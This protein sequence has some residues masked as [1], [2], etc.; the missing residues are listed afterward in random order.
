MF[1]IIGLRETLYLYIVILTLSH[2]IIDI[3]I[4]KTS[5]STYLQI[6]MNQDILD[7]LPNRSMEKEMKELTPTRYR[8][9]IT[10]VVYGAILLSIFSILTFS[11]VVTAI[12]QPLPLPTVNAVQTTNNPVISV[13]AGAQ[14]GSQNSINTTQKSAINVYNV[15][16]VGPKSTA[17]VK[18]TGNYNNAAINQ[19][20]PALPLGW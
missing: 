7:L 8:C 2:A 15:T 11:N 18:Q 4:N 1:L 5:S 17:V 9:R 10:N 3:Y 14:I 6:R 20:S 19:L 16:Q 12:A 13:T